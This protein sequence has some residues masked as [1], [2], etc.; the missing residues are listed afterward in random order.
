LKKKI[1]KRGKNMKNFVE[2]DS[3]VEEELQKMEQVVDAARSKVTLRKLL[4]EITQTDNGLV[5]LQK[6]FTSIVG[7]KDVS[8]KVRGRLKAM[9][10]RCNLKLGVE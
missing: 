4:N 6:R 7:E 10:H 1:L 8:N 5:E 3:G 2:L 9:Q